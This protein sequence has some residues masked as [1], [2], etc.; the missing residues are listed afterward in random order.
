MSLDA[1][2]LADNFAENEKNKTKNSKTTTKN[3]KIEKLNNDTCTN[4]SFR[5]EIHRL[6]KISQNLSLEE[7]I[8]VSYDTEMTPLAFVAGKLNNKPV[9]VLVDGA[10]GC[11]NASAGDLFGVSV[12]R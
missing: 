7:E 6:N 9:T 5:S 1:H 12:T 2:N 11:G 8:C 4:E 3:K 10:G